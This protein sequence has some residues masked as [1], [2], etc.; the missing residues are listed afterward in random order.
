MNFAYDAGFRVLYGTR[1]RNLI[2]RCW[3]ASQMVYVNM[4]RGLELAFSKWNLYEVDL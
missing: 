2:Q 4:L 1:M 3:I